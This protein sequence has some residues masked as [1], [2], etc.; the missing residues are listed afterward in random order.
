MEES[1]QRVKF[2][3]IIVRDRGIIDRCIIAKPHDQLSWKYRGCTSDEKNIAYGAANLQYTKQLL[4]WH[5]ARLH[6]ELGKLVS[7]NKHNNKTYDKLTIR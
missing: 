7:K 4:L 6:A 5:T 3:I 2:A 1:R